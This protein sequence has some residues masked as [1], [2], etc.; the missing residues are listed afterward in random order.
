[1]KQLTRPLETTNLVIK[2]LTAYELQLYKINDGQLEHALGA[3]YHPRNVPFELYDALE[4]EIIP[5]VEVNKDAFLFYTL[6]SI[7]HKDLNCLV[8]DICFKGTVDEEG[9]IEIGYG[10][11]PDFQGKGIMKEA[12]GLIL[13]W[14]FSQEG[15]KR[16]LA[17]TEHDNIPSHSV[18]KSNGFLPHENLYTAMW[19]LDKNSFKKRQ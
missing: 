12:I 5:N 10:T 16:V 17:E 3:Q 14:A 19:Y 11:Y 15:V 6:W 13:E 8:G 7:Y 2:P 9:Q 1:M 18:L 4:Q